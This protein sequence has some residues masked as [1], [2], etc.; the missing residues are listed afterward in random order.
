MILFP[1]KTVLYCIVVIVFSLYPSVVT[2]LDDGITTE[3]SEFCEKWN[4][5][6]FRAFESCNNNETDNN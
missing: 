4:V 1:R 3:T 5:L 2:G 6:E